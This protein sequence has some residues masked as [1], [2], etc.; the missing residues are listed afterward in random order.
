MDP[1]R[2]ALPPES[3]VT[4]RVLLVGHPAPLAARLAAALRG[5]AADVEIAANEAEALLLLERFHPSVVLLHATTLRPATPAM[6]APLARA[7]GCGVIVLL[8][9]DNEAARIAGL[10]AGADDVVSVGAADAELAARVRAVHRRVGRAVVLAHEPAGQI[11][12]EPAHRCLVGAGG[13][14]TALSEAEFIA[15]ETLL[16]A[17]GAAVSREWLGR[18]ALKRPLHSE[19]RSVDQLVLKL[20]RKLVAAGASERII[21][22][23]R[24]QGYVIADPSRFRN[25]ALLP[26][27]GR[28]GRRMESVP[29]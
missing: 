13:A 24:R 19:D 8:A 26:E 10:D 3:R 17:D 21:L 14:R 9:D 29:G 11:L 20:R 23:A 18:V 4:P 25:I 2:F 22:S 1:S 6:I 28:S 16:D 7:G 5:D 27:A 15:L 12:L